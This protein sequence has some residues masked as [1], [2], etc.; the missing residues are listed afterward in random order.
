MSRLLFHQAMLLRASP[1]ARQSVL[2]IAYFHSTRQTRIEVGDKLPVLEDVLTE[3]SPGNKVD[4][5][6]EL[7]DG[8]GLII[9]VPAAFSTFF[10]IQM[11]QISHVS[12][13]C[14]LFLFQM[15][16]IFVLLK[17]NIKYTTCSPER[18]LME[19]PGDARPRPSRMPYILLPTI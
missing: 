12:S 9:G 19:V 4:L 10:N 18:G 16:H 3:N 2:S 6:S 7:S 14:R 8:K 15:F 1:I 13:S 17:C 11:R 5:T